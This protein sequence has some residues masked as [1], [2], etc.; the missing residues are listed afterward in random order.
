M[1]SLLVVCSDPLF[2][3]MLQVVLMTL[4]ISHSSYC[5]QAP[6]LYWSSNRNVLF[7]PVLLISEGTS[8]FEGSKAGNSNFKMKITMEHWWNDTYRGKLKYWEK[9]II[10]R[11]V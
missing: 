3:A 8:L 2:H 1:V 11:G 7:C 6:P 10:Q 9:N 5:L 4:F